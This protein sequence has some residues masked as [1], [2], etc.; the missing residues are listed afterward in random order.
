MRMGPSD[1]ERARSIGSE[2]GLPASCTLLTWR[3]HGTSQPWPS[4]AWRSSWRSGTRSECSV[5]GTDRSAAICGR[6]AASRC[7]PCSAAALRLRS[8]TDPW[9]LWSGSPP[10]STPLRG[11]S[12]TCRS[13]SWPDGGDRPQ[14]SGSSRAQA[15]LREHFELRRVRSPSS[16]ARSCGAVAVALSAAPAARA[17]IRESAPSRGVILRNE[18]TGAARRLD[19]GA[20][21]QLVV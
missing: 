9:A 15:F 20:A 17:R 18:Q 2:R 6:T 4:L 7:S 19:P 8:D 12:H 11:R 5:L 10:F 1:G 13:S 14:I 21:R 3:R 16:P